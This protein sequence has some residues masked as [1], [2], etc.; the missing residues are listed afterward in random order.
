M[1]EIVE[2]QLSG[3]LA[4]IA[5]QLDITKS[6]YEDVKRK[7]EAV[8]EWLSQ[9]DTNL[10]PF[11]P[12]IYPQGSFALGT[13]VRP[14]GGNEYDVDLVCELRL[15]IEEVEPREL[16]W[17]IGC[18][19]IEHK[20]YAEMLEE[21]TRC[22]R[23]KYADEFHMD[24]LPAIPDKEELCSTTLNP[25]LISDKKLRA[26]VCSDPKG[27]ANWF[28]DRMRVAFDERRQVL[29]VERDAN[30][31]EIPEYEVKTPLQVCVQLLKRHRDIHH[32]EDEDK[33]I[34]IIITTLAARAYQ[35]ESDVF[36]AL[37]SITAAMRSGIEVRNG[38]QWVENPV[39]KEENFAE[40]WKDNRR[41]AMLFR[42]WV[43]EVQELVDKLP[44]TR[45]LDRIGEL[46]SK[47]FGNR[48][49]DAALRRL[50]DSQRHLREKGK[51]HMDKAGAL[52]AAKRGIKVQEH[53][54]FGH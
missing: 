33:P 30:V 10:S 8:A 41:K 54:F 3:I 1:S 29:A 9:P 51:L 47:S 19:L 2:H 11:S 12:E 27:Y 25:L 52:S 38:V 42:T 22:W 32:G 15:S 18:R 16:K 50:G 14:I 6:Q 26:W 21:K 31:D 24:I 49:T 34:S 28:M 4:L 5:G 36:Q 43:D 23:L 20:K 40:K 45:G 46:L 17:F 48:E 37:K 35:N 44:E 53:H 13:V 39:R 7:Y